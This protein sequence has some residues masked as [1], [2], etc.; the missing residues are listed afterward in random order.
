MTKKKEILESIPLK[1]KEIIKKNK[2]QLIEDNFNGC[3][4]PEYTKLQFKRIFRGYDFLENMAF[5]RTYIMKKYKLKHFALLEVLLFITPKNL[6]S[7]EDFK[8]IQRIRFDYR[9]IDSLL[10]LGFVSVVN[11][12]KNKAH[13]LYAPTQ[14]A[15]KIV[16]EFYEILSGEKKIPT[17]LLSNSSVASDRWKTDIIKKL[18]KKEASESKKQIWKDK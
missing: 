6:F 14:L 8:D 18:N 12:G 5:A 7:F 17:E 10:Q 9:K 2:T 3:D 16:Q 13:H 11:N 1:A 4:K 15:R